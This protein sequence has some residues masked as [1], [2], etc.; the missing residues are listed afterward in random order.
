[1]YIKSAGHAMHLK[2]NDIDWNGKSRQ[3]LTHNSL[4]FYASVI[5]TQINSLKNCLFDE[6]EPETKIK[7]SLYIT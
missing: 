5:C 1:M 6:H 3:Q 4:E 7:N 2:L